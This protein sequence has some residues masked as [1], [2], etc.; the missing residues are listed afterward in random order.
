MDALA[1]AVITGAP[2]E[3]LER[4]AP[5][6]IVAAGMLEIDGTR[7]FPAPVRLP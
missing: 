1:E 7:V 2:R 3:E 6:E 4:I 5:P